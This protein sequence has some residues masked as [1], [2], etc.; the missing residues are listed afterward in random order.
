MDAENHKL[1]KGAVPKLHE[2]QL[3]KVYNGAEIRIME[4]VAPRWQQF[5]VA[6]QFDPY[7]IQAI[8]KNCKGIVEDASQEI[9]MRWLAGDHDL[10]EPRN[11][12]TLVRCLERS[13]FID[14]ARSVKVILRD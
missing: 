14:V 7:R 5:A 1:R 8:A 9:F 2:L 3:L 12:D 10:I 6:L 4:M 13:N 11:W